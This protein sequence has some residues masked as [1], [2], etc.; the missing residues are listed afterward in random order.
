RSTYLHNSSPSSRVSV[1]IS[2]TASRSNQLAF[3]CLRR[4]LSSRLAILTFVGLISL[5]VAP[6]DGARRP[7]DIVVDVIIQV[8]ERYAHRPVRSGK[9]ATIEQDDRRIL[10]HPEHNVER[11]PG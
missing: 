5:A 10:G 9:A 3:F 11:M 8:R 4:F 7:A 6:R 2:I 1:A